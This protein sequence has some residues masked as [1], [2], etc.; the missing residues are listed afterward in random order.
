MHLQINFHFPRNI[1]IQ[2]KN[3]QTVDYQLPAYSGT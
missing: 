3:D 1:V 2:Y